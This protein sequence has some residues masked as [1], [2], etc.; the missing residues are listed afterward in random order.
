[1]G[2]P[3]QTKSSKGGSNMAETYDVV[4]KVISQEGTCGAEHK[5]GDEW[6]IGSKTPEGICLS[7]FNALFPAARVLRFGGAFPWANDPDLATAACPDAANPVVFELRR[8][9]K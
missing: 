1:M 6:V 2:N 5:V 4:V 7:A 9:R 8:I 3:N